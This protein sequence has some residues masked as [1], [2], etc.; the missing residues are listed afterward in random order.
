MIASSGVE[1]ILCEGCT[2]GIYPT[3]YGT[4]NYELAVQKFLKKK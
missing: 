3:R 4:K 1:N 2:K